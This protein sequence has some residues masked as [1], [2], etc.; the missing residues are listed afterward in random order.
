MNE[1][2]EP[3]DQKDSG[4]SVVPGTYSSQS[5][6]GR[7]HQK[8]KQEGN[9]RFKNPLRVFTDRV[10]WK[11]QNKDRRTPKQPHARRQRDSEHKAKRANMSR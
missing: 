10:S 3:C 8:K 7:E 1:C 2:N 11:C 4:Y 6:A 5:Y 9:H